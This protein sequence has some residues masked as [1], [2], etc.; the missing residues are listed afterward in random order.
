MMRLCILLL[1]LVPAA[2]AHTTVPAADDALC[3]TVG[4]TKEPITT[5]V[6]SGLD[7]IVSTNNNPGGQCA[8]ADRG[9]PVEAFHNAVTEATLIAPDGSEM[10]L[11]PLGRQHGEVGRFTGSDPYMLTAPGQYM[12][13]LAGAWDGHDFTGTYQVS[14]EVQDVGETYLPTLPTDTTLDALASRIQALE[15]HMDAMMQAQMQMED[16]HK[17]DGNTIPAPGAILAA[18]A[19]VG[20]ALIAR[21]R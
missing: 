10:D 8:S 19:I 12:L 3:L 4:H 13:R 2:T 14:D 17:D 5:Y 6:R 11:M 18:A 9:D 20:V 21:R 7:L 1:L 16:A 15:D